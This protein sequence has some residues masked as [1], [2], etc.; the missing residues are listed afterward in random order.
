MWMI[1]LTRKTRTAETRMGSHRDAIGTI[2]TSRCRRCATA[3]TRA[4]FRLQPAR[5]IPVLTTFGQP[6]HIRSG[7]TRRVLNSG[8]LTWLLMQVLTARNLAIL[9]G[10]ATIA[11]GSTTR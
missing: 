3:G 10:A 8:M 11:A 1:E 9:N 7:G 4:L 2:V 5:G 6:H